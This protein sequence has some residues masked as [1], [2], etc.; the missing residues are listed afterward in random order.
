[1]MNWIFE[2]LAFAACLL[3]AI[4]SALYL[5]VR[6]TWG[7]KPAEPSADES[8]GD[9]FDV[10]CVSH[11]EWNYVWQRNQHIMCRLA[12][13]GKVLYCFP[14][15]QR[16]YR[17]HWLNVLRPARRTPSGVWLWYPM[18]L[19][20]S[21]V[22]GWIERFNAWF[23]AASLRELQRRL[24]I[25]CPIL[26]YYFPD[27]VFLV[28]RLGERGLVYDIQDDYA[29]FEWAS[30]QTSERA[31]F[32]LERADQVFT[33]THA[34]YEKNHASARRIRFV[35]NGV[36]FDMFH[37]VRAVPVPI[38]AKYE[39]VLSVISGPTMGYFG[40]ID[41]RVNLA[42]IDE[43]AH[44]RPEWHFLMVGPVV[45]GVKAEQRPNVHFTG[46]VPYSDLPALAQK[47][48]VCLMPFVVN[49]L[50]RAINPTKTLEYFA[51]ERPVVSTPIPDLVRFYGDSIDFAQTPDEWEKEIHK[52]LRP[53]PA[54]L[55][56]AR[57]LARARSWDAVTDI[58]RQEIAAALRGE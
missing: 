24:G 9:A 28:G 11:V 45:E 38:P 33:G 14:V 17:R 54:R 20:G 5:F 56:Q 10:V 29:L 3:K 37:S 50:T 35:L 19:P 21:R 44:R 46:Q 53:N 39:P 30:P 8:L 48:D 57:D 18:V 1:M 32:L 51:L 22:F 15:K 34:L 40:L 25:R 4:P 2:I 6:E 13:Y 43:L 58:F 49:G 36:D 27:L 31:K 12:R 55:A 42:L 16:A 47:F 52:A 26:W 7:T 23:I 41:E